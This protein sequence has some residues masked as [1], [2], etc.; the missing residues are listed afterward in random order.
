MRNSMLKLEPFYSK[1]FGDMINEVYL[2][3]KIDIVN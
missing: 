1:K 3:I 2:Q